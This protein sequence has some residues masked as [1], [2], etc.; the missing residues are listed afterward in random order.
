MESASSI[1]PASLLSRLRTFAFTALALPLRFSG[2]FRR[3]GAAVRLL[4]LLH[5]AGRLCILRGPLHG[6]TH[7]DPAAFGT[8]DSTLDHDQAAV[9]IDLRHFE[10]LRGHAVG[11]VMA[12]HLLVLEGF[13]RILTAAGATQ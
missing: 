1:S 12:V 11:A 10:I 8:R 5:R 2:G 7:H 4:G 3:C 6:I 9:H 13:A